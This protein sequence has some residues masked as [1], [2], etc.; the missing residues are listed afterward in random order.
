MEDEL[1]LAAVDLGAESGR[2]VH[3]RLARG[4]LYL[5][6]IHRFP[7]E[8]VFFGK[9]LYWDFP[10]LFREVKKGLQAAAVKAG[11]LHGIAVDTWGVDFGLLDETGELLSNPVCYRDHRTEHILPLVFAD[12]AQEELFRRTGIQIMSINTSC[13]LRAVR[14]ENPGFLERA[15][16][17]LF[18]PGLFTYFLCGKK[19]NDTTIVSTSQLYN[20]V[21]GDWSW[22]LLDA[23]SLPARIFK[24]V[25]RPGTVLGELTAFPDGE[26]VAGAKVIVTGGHDTASA[27]AAVPAQE[28]EFIYISC[29][30][31]S[32]VGTEL[33]EPL[34]T[35][36]ARELNFSNEIGVENKIRFLKNVMGLWLLQQCRKSWNERGLAYDYPE[37]TACAAK[38]QPWRTLINPDDPVF[39][40]PADMCEAIAS[41]ARRTEQ[42]VPE[43]TGDYVRCILESLALKYC[44]VIKRLQELTGRSYDCIHMVGGGTKNKFLAQLTA[45]VTGREIV[46]DPV[47][48]TAAGNL[49]LQALALGKITDLPA[50]RRVV[51]DS[52]PGESYRPGKTSK[53]TAAVRERF[54]VLNK[55]TIF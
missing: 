46:V 25:V 13:Q 27:V 8:P 48:A 20:P 26:P 50:L 1:N 14:Q 22:E 18:M 6:E 5:E 31:W 44:W 23:L 37:L 9:H 36:K 53:E 49:L 34:L 30:T 2:V 12:A 15:E 54:A 40:N 45:D 21:T 39:L 51:R 7:N 17:L 29:G 33:P 41:Y 3:G 24:P 38:A 11:G 10:G 4:R 35:E 47:E 28:E 32:L 43:S 19:A 16:D 52:F 42:P 55:M